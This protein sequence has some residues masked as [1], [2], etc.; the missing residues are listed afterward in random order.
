[1]AWSLLGF[2]GASWGF[3]NA[4]ETPGVSCGSWE[5]RGSVLGLPGSFM[6]PPGFS[7]GSW[8]SAGSLL[9]L[10]GALWNLLGFPG[11]PEGLL[12]VSWG[13]IWGKSAC[14]PSVGRFGIFNPPH[15]NS[16]PKKKR[17]STRIG[18]PRNAFFSAVSTTSRKSILTSPIFKDGK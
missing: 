2:P 7:W 3:L 17:V 12:E 15:A 9:G 14:F 8:E 5:R 16:L 10:P 1:M 18:T 11:A 4:W 6:E 13:L